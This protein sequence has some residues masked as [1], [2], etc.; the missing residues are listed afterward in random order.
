MPQPEG[1]TTIAEW[2]GVRL[3]SLL[4]AAEYHSRVPIC[5]IVMHEWLYGKHESFKM[6]SIHRLFLA[7]GMNGKDLLLAHGAPVTKESKPRLDAKCQKI[8]KTH[9]VTDAFCRSRRYRVW[10]WYT[11][12]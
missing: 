5:R 9:L 12:I 6:H 11:G 4:Q 3:G 7:Y 1:W 10:S 8:F 2:T